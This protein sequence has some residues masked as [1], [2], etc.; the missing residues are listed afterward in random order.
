MHGVDKITQL[1]EKKTGIDLEISGITKGL[2][3]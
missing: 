3:G 1:V 2:K